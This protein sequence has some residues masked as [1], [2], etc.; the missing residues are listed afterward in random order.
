MTKSNYVA[1]TTPHADRDP[2]V[3]QDK[4]KVIERKLNCHATQLHRTF[5]VANNQ[6]D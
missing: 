4:L 2:V 6:W 1:A 3:A 5:L